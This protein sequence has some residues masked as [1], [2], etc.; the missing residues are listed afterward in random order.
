M[1]LE[2]IDIRSHDGDDDP[3]FQAFIK[4]MELKDKVKR[5]KAEE[6]SALK[7][8]QRFPKQE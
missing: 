4:E 1:A 6:Q 3:C 8:S 5:R 2:E 7:K